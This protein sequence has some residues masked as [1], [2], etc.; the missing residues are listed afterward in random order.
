M[1]SQ[2]TQIKGNDTD[3]GDKSIVIIERLLELLGMANYEE[4]AVSKGLYFG[5]GHFDGAVTGGGGTMEILVRTGSVDD[6]IT[7]ALGG[8]M[9][10]GGE[11]LLEVFQNPTL[12]ADG[13]PLGQLQVNQLS[14]NTPKSTVF[15]TPTITADGTRIFRV[16]VNGGSTGNAIGGSSSPFQRLLTLPDTDYLIRGTNRAA[17]AQAIGINISMIEVPTP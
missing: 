2:S 3:G 15:H 11:A 4:I 12:T 14:T 17:G 16:L 9:S 1:V 10:S 5:S 13:T 6:I 7:T 8:F